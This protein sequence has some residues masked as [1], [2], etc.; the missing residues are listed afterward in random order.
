MIITFDKLP[1]ESRIWIYQAERELTTKEQQIVLNVGKQFIDQWA[2]HGEP[3]TAAIRILN[4]YF[5]VIG[6]D[7][8]LLPSGC[9]I[10]ASIALMRDL[11]NRLQL[12]FFGRTNVPLMMGDEIVLVPLT[13]LKHQIKNR[14]I[15]E[16]TLLVNTLIQNK[17]GLTKW[18]VPLKKSWLSR[19]LPQP[20]DN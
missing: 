9:S 7:D 5:V 12:D 14:E 13:E 16:D 18:I 11:G 17:Q 2:T 15:S 1:E 20:Q 19:Y 6:V 10:D 8:R 3:L 4:G